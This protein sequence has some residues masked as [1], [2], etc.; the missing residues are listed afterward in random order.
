ANATLRIP[1]ALRHS[2]KYIAIFLLQKQL[3]PDK[4]VKMK[5][6][7]VMMK[8]KSCNGQAL[9]DSFTNTRKVRTNSFCNHQQQFCDD[10]R[11][12]PLYGTH[13][14]SSNYL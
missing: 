4:I 13:T 1:N 2:N 5:Q 3:F 14:S 9:H 6:I 11:Y 12:S 7:G 8:K 10:C